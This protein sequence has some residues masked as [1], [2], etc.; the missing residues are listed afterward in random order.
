M[1]ERYR[2]FRAQVERYRDGSDRPDP[3][4]RAVYDGFMA[5][6]EWKDARACFSLYCRLN[7]LLHSPFVEELFRLADQKGVPLT[8]AVAD[9]RASDVVSTIGSWMLGTPVPAAYGVTANDVVVP[10]LVV[11]RLETR[12]R[13][14][15]PPEEEAVAMLSSLLDKLG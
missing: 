2:A 9:F 10:L 5:G 15:N 4:L 14:L 3:Q 12:Y 8:G 6:M 1:L 13:L 7:R 11:E